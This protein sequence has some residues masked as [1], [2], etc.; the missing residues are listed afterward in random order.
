MFA[1][2]ASRNVVL[3]RL[4]SLNQALSAAEQNRILKEAVYKV[5]QSGDPELIS[6]L[7]G[8]ASMG[9]ATAPVNNSLTLIQNL[10]QQEA[11]LRSQVA[12]DSVRYGPAYPQ[13]EELEAQLRGVEQSISEEVHR[14]GERARTDYEIAAR[15]ERGAR[16]A[17]EAQKNAASRL[18]DTV[19]AYGL[20]KQEADSSR[21]L[22]E[23]LLAKLKQAGVL[24]GLRSSNIT[25]VSAAQVPP[26][27][28]PKS[29]NIPVVMAAAAAVGLLLGAALV[30]L[31][32]LTDN[33]VR[34]LESVERTLGV[35]LLAVLPAVER[36]HGK[37]RLGAPSRAGEALPLPP[38]TLP[39]LDGAASMFGEG[40]R[41]LRTALLLSRS[42]R[43]PQVILLTSCLEGEGKTTLALNL[44]ALFAQQG[45]RVLLVD[46][47]L[48]KPTLHSFI[49]P[50]DDRCPGLSSVLAGER[51]PRV[52]HPFASTPRLAMLCGDAVAPFPSELLGS[53]RMRD[54]LREW[55]LDYDF[56][57]LDSAPVLPVTDSVVLSQMSDATLLIARHGVTSK[58][59]LRR[60]VQALQGQQVDARGGRAP[61]GTVLNGVSRESGDFY[62]YFGY[63]GGNY[64]RA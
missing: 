20:A 16:T 23:G 30:V 53:P 64:A 59:A 13:L 32:E 11:G 18:N 17:F 60:G 21:E 38:A 63:Q 42:G 3:E 1:N 7:S 43:P 4:D 56:I 52:V 14:L 6:S 62:E 61:I 46:A 29:P 41:S 33:K 8:N 5:A 31:R 51:F 37:R 2:D 39:A 9:A 22:Y 57:L 12:Q 44:A 36:A 26:P 19:V 55:R 28:R 25:V 50:S 54:L 24:E 58:Q 40:L 45:A 35:P 48:R 49:V 47:D 15:S 34:S 10:R 27:S